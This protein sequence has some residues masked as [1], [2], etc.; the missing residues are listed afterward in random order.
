MAARGAART[1]GQRDMPCLPPG[2]ISMLD[3]QI[4]VDAYAVADG[5]GLTVNALRQEMAAGRVVAV[6]ETGIAEDDGRL[7]LTFRYGKRIWR[8]VRLADGSLVDERTTGP[9]KGQV[10]EAPEALRDAKRAS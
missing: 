8:I 4:T 5:L 10:A 2:T 7:R 6:A 1:R 3:N 9:D